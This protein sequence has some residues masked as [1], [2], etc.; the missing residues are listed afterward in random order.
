MC[1]TN[2]WT[3]CIKSSEGTSNFPLYEAPA[4]LTRFMARVKRVFEGRRFIFN[5]NPSS[6]LHQES[7]S[8][9]GFF[10][11]WYF[12]H[13]WTISCKTL[14]N[15]AC[16]TTPPLVLLIFH[17]IKNKDD[18]LTASEMLQNNHTLPSTL[19]ARCEVLWRMCLVCTK[20]EILQQFEDFFYV[21]DCSQKQYYWVYHWSVSSTV[22][23]LFF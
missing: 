11:C 21:E 12:P 3:S 4:S 14:V 17:I 2:I 7:Y 18:I 6:Y 22:I 16:I 10:V 9:K 23:L 1:C 13:I 15:T 20:N 8:D 19:D 5:A